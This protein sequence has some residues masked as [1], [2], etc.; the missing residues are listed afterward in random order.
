VIKQGFGPT[1]STLR[2]GE[3]FTRGRSWQIYVAHKGNIIR[4]AG[5]EEIMPT[6]LWGKK[7]KQAGMLG[8]KSEYI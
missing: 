3:P 6:S 8:A 4:T 5:L 7:A 2:M 1:H